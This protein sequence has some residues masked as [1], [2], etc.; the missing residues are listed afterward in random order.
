MA[1]ASGTETWNWRDDDAARARTRAEARSRRRGLVQAGVLIAFAV[2]LRYL[3]HHVTAGHVFFV[4]GIVVLLAAL[5]RPRLLE[6]LHRFG[7]L[8][9]RGAGV[10]LTWL[11]LV[12]FFVVCV[13]PAGLVLRLRGSDPLQR[14]PLPKGQT[15]WIPRRLEP[16]PASL[17]RQFLV[18]D[19]AARRLQRPEG[20]PA[21]RAW[22]AADG[23][24]E[25]A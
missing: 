1:R 3:W 15:G 6:P 24:R 17:A 14:R 2:L 4:A 21:A 8:V 20:P 5:W 16:T 22:P 18:E 7:A 13:V 23:S 10:G 11:L 9:G 25:R 12:P 19:R